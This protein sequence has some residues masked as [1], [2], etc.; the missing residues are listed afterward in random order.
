MNNKDGL[1]MTMLAD[2]PKW[3]CIKYDED[4]N[5]T[6]VREKKL[7]QM[8]QLWGYTITSNEMIA[9]SLKIGYCNVGAKMFGLGTPSDLNNF[10]KQDVWKT[11]F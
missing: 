1:I 5:V 4:G 8:K 11:V 9:D 3:S 6:M 10:M 7:Y 2:D